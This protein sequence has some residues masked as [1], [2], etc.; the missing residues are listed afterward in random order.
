M[1]SPVS[2]RIFGR[3]TTSSRCPGAAEGATAAGRRRGR[4]RSGCRCSGC[5]RCDGSGR[6]SGRGSCRRHAAVADVL[7]DVIEHVFARD[8][9]TGARARDRGGIETVLG[10]EPAHDRR[11]Q[12]VAGLTRRCRRCGSSSGRLCGRGAPVPA[13]VRARLRARGGGPAAAVL[14]RR[15]APLRR[16]EPGQVRRR[17]ARASP[18]ARRHRTEMTAISAP[19][20]TV[21]PS[22]TLISAMNPAVGDGTSV[23]TLS[24]ETSNSGS[25]TA[26]GSPTFLNHLV[27]V[28][29]VT[30]S[31]SWGIVTSA[32]SRAGS[33]RSSPARSRRTARRATGAAG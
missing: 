14:R 16:P 25:S 17:A 21:S 1:W 8:A 9:T 2:L 29:S 30:V 32:I 11:E 15:R 10:D 4:R 24:V 7:V 6:C 28:P 18:V 20:S 13:Q 31:P 23:S 19:T 22:L 27:I 26:T 5:G 33:F 3:V 12:L